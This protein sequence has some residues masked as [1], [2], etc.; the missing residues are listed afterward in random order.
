VQILVA[1]GSPNADDGVIIVWVPESIHG[2]HRATGTSADSGVNDKYYARSGTTNEVM[3]HRHLAAI[4]SSRPSPALRLSLSQVGPNRLLFAV[5]NLGGG[6]ARSVQVRL[7]L[8]L[9]TDTPFSAVVESVRGDWGRKPD[10]IGYGEYRFAF[11]MTNLLYPQDRSEMALIAGYVA[12][13][14]DT[15]PHNLEPLKGTIRAR[16]DAED[17]QPVSIEGSI[18]TFETAMAEAV[19]PPDQ[20]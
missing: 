7:S 2:P 17:M 1:K 12:K 19:F 14:T 15:D 20:D 5:R 6:V 9:T 3:S 16:I 18:P 8:H 11:V 13:G 4:F 10:A